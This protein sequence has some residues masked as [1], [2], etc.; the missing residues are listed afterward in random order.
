MADRAKPWVCGNCRSINADGT[1]RCYSCRA[2]KSLAVDAGSTA[3]P[4]RITEET[5]LPTRVAVAQKAGA[6]YKS[7]A[8]LATGVTAV[9]FAV[10]VSTGV[11]TAWR[12]RIYDPL[13]PP[14]GATVSSEFGT[15]LTLGAI[16]VGTWLLGFVAWGAWLGRVVANVP[17]LGGGWPRTSPG[18]AF[19]S[20]VVPFVNLFTATSV[21][22][23]VLVRISPPGRA[24]S[25]LLTVWWLA[26]FLWASQF[27][28]LI[29]GPT[30]VFRVVSIA[31][32]SF[33][34]LAISRY[35]GFSNG[36]PYIVNDLL[37]EAVLLLA[38]GLALRLVW[39]IEALQEARLRAITPG[40]ARPR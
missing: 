25:G 35:T 23:D 27:L 8:G 22:R 19:L 40:P 10:I 14:S 28:S 11:Y 4:I 18:G 33:I 5:P 2:P 21:M 29:P 37:F 39:R 32:S 36:L 13:I 3:P 20:S 15:L 34:V 12:I 38:A 26:V 9:V 7:S 6:T 24:S 17:A 16:A 30:F 1:T 31:V